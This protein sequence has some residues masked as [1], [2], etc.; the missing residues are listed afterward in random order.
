MRHLSLA[1][2]ALL[3]TPTVAPADDSL[4]DAAREAVAARHVRDSELK[5]AR[6]PR[7]PYRDLASDGGVLVGL[8]L[9]LGGSP[10]AERVVAVRPVYRVGGRDRNGPP[11][12]SFLS[13]EV[14][15]TVRLVA[16]DGYA[17]A[18]VRVNAG[19]QVD[20]LAIRFARIDRAWLQTADAYESDWV[21]ANADKSEWLDG[22]GRPVV[23]LFARLDGDAV[24]GL[25]LTFA[26]LPKPADPPAGPAPSPAPA[27]VAR[28]GR[29]LALEAEAPG[30]APRRSR[31]PYVVVGVSIVVPLALVAYLTFR[32]DSGGLRRLRRR[33][34][35]QTL[36]PARWLPNGPNGPRP[37][38]DADRPS[39]TGMFEMEEGP[40]R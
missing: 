30:P 29:K 4:G 36:P 17:V 38:M 7:T 27:A 6:E 19:R 21:G 35:V 33:E 14:A 5:G 25:G 32:R 1:A 2:A 20:G 9:G 12:G 11:A 39:L 13:D 37:V 15:R 8:E 28:P 26:E 10:P 3:L 24:R 34:V 23:G 22:E 31:L 16:R 18:A 40:W